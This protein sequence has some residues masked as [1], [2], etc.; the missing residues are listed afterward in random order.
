MASAAVS[1]QDPSKVVKD[2]LASHLIPD[3]I[4]DRRYENEGRVM[5]YKKGKLLGKVLLL[6]FAILARIKTECYTY[7]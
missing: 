2:P 1:E 5:S 7:T 3:M 4:E 6:F